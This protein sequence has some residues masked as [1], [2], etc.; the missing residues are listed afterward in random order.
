MTDGRIVADEPSTREEGKKSVDEPR[1]EWGEKVP[2]PRGD[3]GSV[4]V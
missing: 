2:P 3:N 1:V 4:R